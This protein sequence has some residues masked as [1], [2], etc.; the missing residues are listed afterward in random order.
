MIC[1]DMIYLIAI[2]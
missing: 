1:Y 2:G